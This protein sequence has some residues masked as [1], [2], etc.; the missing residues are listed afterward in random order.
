MKKSLI[1]LAALSAFATVAQAQSNVSIYGTIDMGVDG[2]LKSKVTDVSAGTTVTTKGSGV[3]QQAQG[4]LT[5]SRLGFR[6]NEDLGGGRSASFNL[7]YE[8]NPGVGTT[9]TTNIRTS[10]VGLSDKALGSVNVGRQLTG[11]HN[12]IAG[13]SP[14]SGNN[15]VGD[16][17]YSSDYR[18]H[19]A[20]VRMNN[21]VAYSTPVINGFQARVDYSG[22]TAD[23]VSDTANSGSKTDNLGLSANFATG[24]LKLSAGTHEVKA[25]TALRAAV[26]GLN[27]S[28]STTTTAAASNIVAPISAITSAN[29]ETKTRINVYAAQYTIGGVTINALIGDNKNTAEGVQTSKTK[30]Q[31]IGLS[32]PVGKTTLVAQY[33]EGELI[34]ATDA[35]KS[36]R[37]AYQLGAIYN[38]SKR[39]N[40]YAVYGTQEQK[41]KASATT[42][43]IG[44][45]TEKT[46]YA[47]GLRHSF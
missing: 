11:I 23:Q 32:Y 6:G 37:K 46:Q 39:T 27:S 13:F 42:A 28:G 22:D 7:E 43:T 4:A 31:Q 5:S 3:A 16:I 21:S 38:L 29:D 19:T 34:G 9:T 24:A 10:V 18:L 20:A 44:D 8:M 41:V 35:E 25:K 30:A 33:G 14:L 15:M 36:D 47:I 1:A 2:E 40:M 26:N 17:A 12:V 45:K